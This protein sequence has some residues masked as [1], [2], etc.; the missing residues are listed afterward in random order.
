MEQDDEGQSQQDAQAALPG[1]Q[2]PDESAPDESAAE[3][4]VDWIE[5]EAAAALFEANQFI[6]AIKVR[7]ADG[8]I[9]RLH[10]DGTRT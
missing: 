1:T 4:V 2:P 3:A 6:D 9:G 10:R 7:F 8:V 5:H